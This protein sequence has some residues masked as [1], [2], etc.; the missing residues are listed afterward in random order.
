M[1]CLCPTLEALPLVN[2]QRWQPNP[3][4]QLSITL[5][6]NHGHDPGTGR[7]LVIP[8][9]ATLEEAMYME[10]YL[11]LPNYSP[12]CMFVCGESSAYKVHFCNQLL[13]IHKHINILTQLDLW[14]KC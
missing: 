11:C 7:G 9:C 13:Y 2:P 5:S 14:L 10:L 4:I 8:Y 1:S 3:N 12:K 6:T